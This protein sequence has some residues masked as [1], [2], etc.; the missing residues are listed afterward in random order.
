VISGAAA[1]IAG[2]G[3]SNFLLRR[4]GNVPQKLSQ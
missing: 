2:D 1:Q 4:I 3:L